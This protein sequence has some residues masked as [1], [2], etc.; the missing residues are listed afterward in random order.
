MGAVDFLKKVL[1]AFRL[2]RRNYNRNGSNSIRRTR[3][4]LYPYSY[5]VAA[6]IGLGVFFIH[7]ILAIPY[8][9]VVYVVLFM[10][11]DSGDL[12]A[13]GLG[14]LDAGITTLLLNLFNFAGALVS[15][16]SWLR[17]QL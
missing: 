5:V 11:A 7:P 14:A 4:G 3:R 9:A 16:A 10:D 13:T 6:A 17:S 15:A 12:A 1:G 2:F 8:T